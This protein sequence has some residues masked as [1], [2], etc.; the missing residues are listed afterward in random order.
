MEGS[1]IEDSTNNKKLASE[2]SIEDGRLVT[3]GDGWT[4][5]EAKILYPH[6]EKIPFELIGIKLSPREP[7]YEED[8]YE[9]TNLYKMHLIFRDQIDENGI[10]ACSAFRFLASHDTVKNVLDSII[11]ETYRWEKSYLS[12]YDGQILGMG[13]LSNGPYDQFIY[14]NPSPSQADFITFLECL[15]LVMSKAIT[16]VKSLS[17]HRDN[18]ALVRHLTFMVEDFI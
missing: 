8:H 11:E 16:Y 12:V 18:Y 14:F 4:I 6:R 9:I 5:T 7:W 1:N 10:N 13:E 3:R 17:N 15:H 2:E